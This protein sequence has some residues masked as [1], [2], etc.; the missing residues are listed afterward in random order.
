M[1]AVRRTTSEEFVTAETEDGLRLDGALVRPTLAAPRP[2]G[3]IVVGG[4]NGRFTGQIGLSRLLAEQGYATVAGGSRGEGFGMVFGRDE[5]G[6]WRL[7]GGGWERFSESPSD[8]ASWI[9]FA[10]TR[11]IERVIIVG[12]SLGALKVG[13]YQSE[14]QDQRVQ[15][16]A[17]ISPPGRASELE[18][19][20]VALAERMVAE[21][22]ELELLPFGSHTAG[23]TTFSAQTMLDRARTNLDVYGFHPNQ[24]PQPRVATI[25]CPIF[26]SFGTVNDV[27]GEA[28]LETIRR[29]ARAAPRV[30]THTVEGANHGY[31][32]RLPQ[33]AALLTAWA[34]TLG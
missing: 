26:A 11:G 34:A 15:G 13:Y 25:G 18:P 19:R 28:E 4:L 32:G 17:A 20:F 22:R 2:I 23:L 9:D 14:R 24:T 30:E 33:L 3:F 6:K 16:V 8:I 21:G 12:R 31:A 1:P 5:D 7:G 10:Q 27:G 29:N